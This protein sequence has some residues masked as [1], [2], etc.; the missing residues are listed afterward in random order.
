MDGGGRRDRRVLRADGVVLLLC[1]SKRCEQGEEAGTEER[2]CR[3]RSS[4]E[5]SVGGAEGREE[6]GLAGEEERVGTLE[7]HHSGL[8][9][10]V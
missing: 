2:V 5:G 6:E 8:G 3:G 7:V 1:E 4:G 9:K 10:K